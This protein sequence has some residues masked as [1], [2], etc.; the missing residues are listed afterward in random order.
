MHMLRHLETFGIE[1]FGSLNSPTR[2]V[3]FIQ[4]DYYCTLYEATG[5]IDIP[6]PNLLLCDFQALVSIFAVI[7]GL[8]ITGFTNNIAILADAFLE[9]PMHS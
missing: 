4:N 7:C 2:G 3:R 9:M 5:Q 6:F 8:K 1:Y